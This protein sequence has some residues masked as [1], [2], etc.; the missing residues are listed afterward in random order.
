MQRDI[1]DIATTIFEERLRIL[2]TKHNGFEADKLFV[3]D[4]RDLFRVLLAHAR[5]EEAGRSMPRDVCD[6]VACAKLQRAWWDSVKLAK[7]SADEMKGFHFF[8]RRLNEA[9]ARTLF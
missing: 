9:F 5:D 7:K 8:V 3:E 4:Q 6:Q 2:F 1:I